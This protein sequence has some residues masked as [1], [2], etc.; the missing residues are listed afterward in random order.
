[1]RKVELWWRIPLAMIGGLIAL[2]I[3]PTE[4]IWVLSPLVPALI[5]IAT[6]GMGFRLALLT[7]FL[8]GQ[9]YYI[10]HIEW[11][12][13]YLGPVPLLALSTLMSIYFAL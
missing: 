3:F 11:I 9:V 13:L 2:Y 1:M 8:A 7:G 10:A 6:L 5:L 12:S 4:N